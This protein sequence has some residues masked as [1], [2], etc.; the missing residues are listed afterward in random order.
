MDIPHDH[1][2]PFQCLSQR[3]KDGKTFGERFEL[4]VGR[5]I[6]WYTAHTNVPR[7]SPGSV[8]FFLAC[9]FVFFLYFRRFNDSDS[10]L[11]TTS[12]TGAFEDIQ[13]LMPPVAAR[14]WFLGAL[15]VWLSNLSWLYQYF[16]KG[17]F[18]LVL[19]RKFYY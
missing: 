4:D 11:P 7:F 10:Y 3:A 9:F 12:L 1:I 13:Q 18:N 17:M 14:D 16:F 19:D 5:D 6:L 2:A 15:N 8:F